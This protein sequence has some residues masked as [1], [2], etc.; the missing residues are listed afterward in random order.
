MMGQ[1]FAAVHDVMVRDQEARP[2]FIN[3]T[4]RTAF[5]FGFVLGPLLGS[6]LAALVSF[7]AAFLVA[8]S[9]NLLCLVPLYG[10]NIP[11]AAGSE[12]GSG[13]QGQ[14]QIN[15]RLYVFV[16][17]CTLVL[18]GTA[19]RITYLPIDVTKHLGGSLRQYGTV[20]AVSPLAEP[21]TMPAAG[22]LALRFRLGHLFSIGLA[23]ATIEYLI[24]AFNTTVWQV[25]LTQLIDALVVAVVFGLGLT[26][27]Q[28]LSPGRAG[29]V[30]ST[31]GSAF[32]IATLIG[33]M[34]GGV[35]ISALGVPHVFFIPLGTACVA[36]IMF[37]VLDRTSRTVVRQP[38]PASSGAE[39][40]TG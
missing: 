3:T 35:S 1:A 25:Y 6:Q 33:N 36:L 20:V 31:F 39:G 30:S 29:F 37:V 14:S 19:L 13:A 2:G 34:I 16:A 7:Q 4:I 10:L 28:Q 18:I 23:A 9:L 24:L 27:A 38:P 22:L 12:P 21:V 40:I 17:L 8:G 5:S 15:V 32:G 26:Y 11:A